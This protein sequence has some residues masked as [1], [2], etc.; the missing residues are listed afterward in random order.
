MGEIIQTE[1]LTPKTKQMTK[2]STCCG[3]DQYE[4]LEMCSMCMEWADFEEE[5]IE[6]H[7]NLE[8]MDYETKENF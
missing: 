7:R 1:F 2:I 5:D 8:S 6:E 3:A 4:D